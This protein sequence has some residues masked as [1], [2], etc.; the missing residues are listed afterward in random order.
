ML[1][2]HRILLIG[3]LLSIPLTPSR[4][5]SA[6]ADDRGREPDLPAGVSADW[7]SRVQRSIQLEEYA[8]V[9]DGPSGAS[10]RA[11]NPAHRF[12]ARFDAEGLRLAP[13]DG[14][15]WEW[16][17]SLTG[18]GRPG[19][20]VAADVRWLSSDE[21][22]VE[23]DRGSLTEW[24][25]NR[26]D[27]LEHGFTVP[28]RPQVDGDRLV[29]DMA[30]SGALRPVFAEDGQ[31]VDFFGAGDVSALR[32]AKLVVTDAT[33]MARPARMK[34]ISGGIRIIVDDS[35][36]IYPL[37]VDPL[38]TS[39]SWTAVGED[40]NDSFGYSVATAGDVNGDGYSDVVVGAFRN[41]STGKAYLYLG[42]SSGLSASASWTAV[43]EATDD[44]F[45]TSVA[46]AGDVNGDGY[47]DVVVGAYGNASETGK[48]YLYLGGSSGLSASASWTA[49]GEAIID[50][51]GHSVSTA[52]DVDGDGYSDV[53]VGAYAVAS[54]TG[55]AYLYLGGSS[56]L[57]VSASWTAAGEAAD[58]L[59]GVSVAT[60][61]DVN[62]DGYSD[63]VVG[64]FGNAGYT[65]KAYLYLGG[66]S[67][68]AASTSWT[69]VG[70][71]TGDSFGYSVATAGDVNGDGYSDVVV[72]AD[73][74]SS[75]TGKAY[76]YLGGSSGLSPSAS[77]TAV[78]E[79]TQDSFGYPVATAGDVNGDGYSDVVVVADRN[80][81]LTGKAYLYLGGSTG[82]SAGA[83][84]TA[85]GE[86]TGDRF[87]W[88]AATA[89]DVNG[90]G[91]SD[92]VVG[93]Y[94]N[95]GDTGKAYLYLGG[96]S[97]PSASASWTA[98]GEA[99]LDQF[100]RSVATAGDVNGDGYSDVVAGAHRNTGDTGKAYLYLGEP[101]DLSAD[102]SWTVAGEATGDRLGYSVS[103]A[104]D[105][106]GDG[107]SDVVVGAYGNASFTGKAYLYLGGSSGLSTSASWTA[108][109]EAA[110]DYFGYSVST[111]GDVNGDGYSDVVVGAYRNTGFTGK[112][113]LYLGGSSGLSASAS[114]TAA[115]EATGGSFGH[116]VS[117]A[118]DVDGDGYS[119]VVVGAYADASS[120]GKAYLYLGG[121]SGLSASA[122]WTAVGE[123][124]GDRF[125]YSASTAGDVNGDGYSDVVVSAY[126]NASS[127][128]KA[129]VYL[130][131][132]S[133]L[134]A[135]ASWTASG[136][137]TGDRFGFSVSTAGDANGDG[138]SD[139]V[140]GA[141]GNASDT[142]RAY[143]YLGGS[144]GL[145]ASA[146]WTATG[147]A[148]GDRFGF[149]VSTA[150]DVN[151]DGFSD[152]VVG[153]YASA[154]GT[155]KAYLYLGGGGAGVPLVPRQLRAD[156]SAPIH[157]GGR[158]FEQQFRLGLTLRSPVGR[159]W[160]QLQWQIAPWGGVFAPAVNPIES[161][162][163]W[164]ANPVERTVPETLPEDLQRYVWRAR[165]RYHPAQSPFVPWGPWLTP[166]ANGLYEADLFGTS[167]P[168]PPPCEVPDEESYI[169]TVT[170]DGN[171]KPV[172]HYQDP[173][174]PAAV[175]G[176]N[177]YRAAA[178][179][180]PWDVLGSNVV[181]MDE[182]TPDNQYVD[183]TGDAGGPWYYQVSPWNEACG[184]EGPW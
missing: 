115:G 101:G 51:F 179:T 31:A 16:G 175:T 177:V 22:K 162:S 158:A 178:P 161:D 30:L 45:G 86:A 97:G 1:R 88:S 152:V 164:Y 156:L 66:S 146:S 131:G 9:A 142:G 121:S 137:A 41:G 167:E 56:G 166:S 113:Y 27:G 7:W 153:A 148:T 118:G 13:T 6:W 94:G 147:E 19:D 84:W 89:G 83:S 61:G 170:I 119:D 99:A 103:T 144:S 110:S 107:Y 12:A 59:F 172:I 72:G 80:A 81:G 87:G 91:Y 180:G 76:L 145:S 24:F 60:A 49:T 65:G 18:W 40:T 100:S 82:L 14:S 20:T 155:G 169:T 125:G 174:Q 140:V 42:G 159:V 138:F 2:F 17:L 50:R 102:A 92:V 73:G 181:D 43:G 176:F 62:G 134:A 75:S 55:K 112:A 182:G 90:D 168:P 70:E 104:G 133:G 4:I 139:V 52:G 54:E 183:Q 109:G 37:S 85:A 53:V 130:G 15:G 48:A 44:R 5:P 105:V 78:G 26:P 173:N 47:S 117:T 116:S 184:A 149:S 69:A 32:Y 106:N 171:G 10:F 23:L 93:A 98:V 8:I 157:V 79:A 124:T 126:S 3:L 46:T 165:V 141:Y 135:G 128:G 77:W 28:V 151:G 123:A 114:W 122:S 163:N 143:L 39:P 34:P 160:R 111:A 38:A 129:Y 11:V 74:N 63:V 58:D 33:G 67:G 36:A 108:V 29:F 150:G 132:W 154:G 64:A 25:V 21:D 57:S 127:T 71:A 96:S 136:E 68:L 120:T 35:G 95:A